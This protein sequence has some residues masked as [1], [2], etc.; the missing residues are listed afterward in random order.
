METIQSHSP[1]LLPS[2][3][4]SLP[5][6]QGAYV[7]QHKKLRAITHVRARLFGLAVALPLGW[8]YRCA[9]P[10]RV[11]SSPPFQMIHLRG[12]AAAL[13]S[14]D[15]GVWMLWWPGSRARRLPSTP[16]PPE[17]HGAA[18]AEC[19]RATVMRWLRWQGVISTVIEDHLVIRGSS[20][21]R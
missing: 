5:F 6:A 11:R 4:P 7:Q 8:G 12:R 21:P 13:L 16:M 20:H 3:P 2:P 18:H 1:L 14:T 10:T 19:W 9:A 15:Y 17:A